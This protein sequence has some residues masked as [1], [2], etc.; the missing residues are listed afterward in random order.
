MWSDAMSIIMMTT[1]P[2]T[3]T[4]VRKADMTIS[5]ITLSNR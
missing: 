3:S 2:L 4:A 5:T 1:R